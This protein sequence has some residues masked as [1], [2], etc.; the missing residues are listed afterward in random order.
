MTEISNKDVEKI[1]KLARI[2]VSEEDKEKYHTDLTNIFH[3][4][5]ELNE[6]DTEGVLPFSGV[7]NY[8][9]RSR[10]IDEVADG[11][12]KDSVLKNAPESKFGCFVVPKVVGE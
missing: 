6:V 11:N 8:S 9:L 2:A 1:A 5:D 10:E 12:I 4:I 3:M 7:G